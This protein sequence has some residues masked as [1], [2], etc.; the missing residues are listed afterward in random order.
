MGEFAIGQSV[1]RFEDPRLLRGGGQYVD[2]IVLPRMAFGHVLRSPHAH[3]KIRK[4]DIAA[5]KAAPGVLAVLTGEDWIK[6][7]W[8]NMPVPA[9]HKRRDGSPNFQPPYP[10]LV[11]DRVRFIGDYV[12]FVVAETKNQAM[13]ASELIEVDYEPLPAILGTGQAANA[14]VPLVWENCPNNI[15]F[16]AIHGDKAKTE[17]AFAKAAHIVKQHLVINRVTTASMEPRG[18]VGDYNAITD[19]YTIYTT[20]QRAHPYRAELAKL[21]LK[22]PEHKVRVIAPDIGG[23]FGMKSA[24]YNEVPL[25]LLGSKVTGRPVKWMSTRS[26][27]FLSDAMAR[28]N[29]TEA[30]L[31]LDKDG[32]FLAFRVNSFVNAGAYLQSGFQAYTGNL[33]TLAGV[34]RT[35][36]MYVELTAVFTHTQPCRPYRGNG[37]PEAAYVIE[38]MVDVAAKQLKMDP[39]ELRRKNYIPPELMPFKTSLTFTYDLGEFEKGMD[40]ALKLADVAGFAKRKTE[41]K[42]R[43][44]LRGLG[45]SNTIERAAAPSFEGAEIRFDR[46]GTVSIFS[47]SINQGQGHET[48]FKQVVADK[49]GIHPNDIEYI[50]GDTDKVFFGEGTGGSR[51]ATMSGAAFH[52][53]GEKVITKAKAIAAFNMKVDAADVNFNEGIFSSTKSNQTMTIKDVALAS[54]NPAK[55]PNDMEAGL[56][57]TAVYK[58][59]VENFPNGVHVCEIEVDPDTGKSEIVRYSVV[60][61][62]G[63]V[64][65]PLLLKGQIVGGVAMGVGQILKEDIHFDSEGQLTTGSFMDYAM[66]RAHDFC[67]IEVKANPVPT[68]TNPLGVKGAGEAGCVGAMPAVA[69]ALVDAL[70]EFGVQH[71]AMP[72]TPE[73][74]WRAIGNGKG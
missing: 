22:V 43:G 29:V 67:P 26:E 35:P 21:V 17:A 3:A 8:G 25:C 64:M 71:I 49:L 66:P 15:C 20:L 37:R 19:H 10:A 68:K 12:A 42:K 61:D 16:T 28:D 18:S 69:N 39:A 27:A 46:G 41:L 32:T 62:V 55:I 54:L 74:V 56:Y 30:E 63:T 45:M 60:D 53:A 33:G 24:I 40:M 70:A 73:V 5:A 72:A 14:G 4:I 57:A 38:R 36:A 1:P 9:T 44:K 47:G 6:S 52:N 31:A 23:S 65:N 34:Y 13:D 58:A 59:D 2:D 50:Q 51:S 7:G 11:K 48:T